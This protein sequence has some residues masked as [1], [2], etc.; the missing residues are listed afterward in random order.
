MGE[1]VDFVKALTEAFK[2]T[3]VQDVF[4]S[5]FNP[6]M[7]DLAKD[8][9]NKMNVWHKKIVDD[10]RSEMDAL[11]SNLK[12]KD[13]KIKNLEVEIA[14]L[15]HDQD[16]LEQYTRRTSLRIS[17]LP[18]E[19]NEDV[20]TKVLDLCNKKLR[21]PV[22]PN[23]IERVNRLGRPGGSPR[24][25]LVKFATYGTRASVFK[26]KAVLRPGGRHPHAPW[27][28]GDAAGLAQAP[29]TTEAPS[30]A[31][32]TED[33]GTNDDDADNDSDTHTDY[34]KFFISEDLTRDRQFM[35]GGPDGRR[36]ARKYVIVGQ[37]MDRLFYG[38]IT[39]K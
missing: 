39:M 25:I 19:N 13:D 8:F 10:M 35:F 11:R 24:Q 33:T 28:L 7:D 30:A 26:A 34:S 23:E 14:A 36:K 15:K 4:K 17:G 6:V 18:E 29:D 1:S 5:M 3:A 27:T 16:W 20:C 22:E 37:P 32:E 31:E 38:T 2:D 9:E 21:I 12:M